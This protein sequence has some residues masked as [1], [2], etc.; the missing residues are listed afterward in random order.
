MVF[1]DQ[2]DNLPVVTAV[3]NIIGYVL[4]AVAGM[5]SHGKVI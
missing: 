5:S 4:D 1:F 2:K 3:D